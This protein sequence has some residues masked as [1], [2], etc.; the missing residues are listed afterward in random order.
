MIFLA[1]LAM[2]AE[3]KQKNFDIFIDNIMQM[4]KSN[5]F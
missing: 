4:Q 2:R 1:A 3:S 5:P